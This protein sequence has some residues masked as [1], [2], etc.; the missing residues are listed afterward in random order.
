MRP[1]PISFEREDPV[2]RCLDLD[3]TSTCATRT[4]FGETLSIRLATHDNGAVRV[5]LGYSVVVVVGMALVVALRVVWRRHPPRSAAGFRRRRLVALCVVS[6]LCGAATW[7]GTGNVRA[8]GVAALVAVA[9]GVV[10]ELCKRYVP[11]RAA[12]GVGR[13]PGFEPPLDVAYSHH[14][15]RAP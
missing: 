12:R 3:Q 13:G 2:R 8:G 4:P 7:A 10:T 5:V 1:L 9:T 6:S 14:T 15:R 11:I